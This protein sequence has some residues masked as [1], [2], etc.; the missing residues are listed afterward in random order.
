[1][2][3][4][5]CHRRAHVDCIPWPDE[6]TKFLATSELPDFFD[7]SVIGEA[8]PAMPSEASSFSSLDERD[9]TA[10]PP[11]YFDYRLAALHDLLDDAHQ[12]I[13][14]LKHEMTTFRD[15]NEHQREQ[16]EQ[17]RLLQAQV[18]AALEAEMRS[19]REEFANERV[20]PPLRRASTQ[21]GPRSEPIEVPAPPQA[22]WPAF[23]DSDDQEDFSDSPSPPFDM[24]RR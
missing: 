12:V 20:P 17:D 8:S 19:M 16:L 21:R 9:G 10:R 1:M 4:A 11:G 18:F 13:S 15:K 7:P 5:S 23:G 6:E 14:H 3:C 2:R 24:P 22:D